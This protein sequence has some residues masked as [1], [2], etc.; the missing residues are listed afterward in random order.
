MWKH[1]FLALVIGCWIGCDDEAEAPVEIAEPEVAEP[2]V[3]EPEPE[4]EI[5]EACARV[6]VVAWQGA[7]HASEEITRTQQEARTRA[8]ELLAR[9]DQGES[10]EAVARE[11]SDASSSGP[12]GGLIGTF[13]RDDWPGAHQVL[14]G[15]V[16]GV[17][18][19]ARTQVI[20]APYGYV[21]AERCAVEKI[22]TR[23]ILIRYAGAKN[24]D[25]DVE[26]T[27]E[28][29]QVMATEI[30]QALAADGADFEAVARERSEDS[31]A[32]NGGDVGE[33]GRGRLAPEYEAVAF[34]LR[35]GQVSDV[36]ETEFGYH[37]I[38]RVE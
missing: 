17:A 36:V 23:H 26:R 4:P 35:P 38:Q 20:E 9:V 34:E 13:A 22:H 2:E 5:D 25:D 31:S 32:S 30:R 37:I 33:V 24:A 15:P 21:F 12:R 3:A 14:Q 18:V 27:K 7:P 29:A 11:N 19:G 6:V 16:M 28:A 8:E 1:V 10:F